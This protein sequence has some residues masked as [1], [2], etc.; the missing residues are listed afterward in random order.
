MNS[1]V[2]TQLG[3]ILSAA[4]RSQRL[5]LMAI[6]LSQTKLR[7]NAEVVP[8]SQ[9]ERVK[10][11]L[12]NFFSPARG[13]KTNKKQ[14]SEVNT[15]PQYRLEASNRKRRGWLFCNGSSSASELSDIKPNERLASSL[16]W[17]FR[18]NFLVLFAVMCSCFFAL[19]ICFACIILG[20]EKLDAECLKGK[21]QAEASSPH[22]KV[23]IIAL[24]L[25]TNAYSAHFT[26]PKT[27]SIFQV[28]KKGERFLMPLH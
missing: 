9:K 13:P 27:F 20:I 25:W 3:L 10:V 18:S 11:Q 4:H 12:K 15:T 5:V 2:C 26:I 22:S 28:V 19:I 16:H 21:K 6:Q 1:N 17:M 23:K 24:Q 7:S 8:M 14:D